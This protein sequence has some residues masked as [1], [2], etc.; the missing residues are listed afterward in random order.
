MGRLLTLALIAMGVAG[1]AIIGWVSLRSSP[2]AP[3][4]AATAIAAPA[5]PAKLVLVAVGT[6]PG[7]TLLKPEEIGDR[8]ITIGQ[9]PLDASESTPQSR[10]S[11][12]GAMVR[13]DLKPGDVIVPADIIRPGDRGFLAAVLSPGMRAMT[14]GTD[15]LAATL[16]LVWPGDHVDVILTQQADAAAPAQRVFS[17]AV[18]S[19]A[20]VLAVDQQLQGAGDQGGR[21]RSVTLEVTPEQATRLTVATRLGKLAL[22]VRAADGAGPVSR[23]PLGGTTWAGDVAPGLQ[24]AAAPVRSSTVHVWQG[25]ADGKE[26]RF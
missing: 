21:A 17:D 22:S 20:R 10:A 7:G 5:G 8:S 15:T 26:F 12:V 18:L 19:N 25:S 3:A 1:L 4:P 6:L 9:F 13:H 11:L 23:A 16:D 2:D 24:G 14:L